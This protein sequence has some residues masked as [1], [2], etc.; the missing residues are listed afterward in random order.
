MFNCHS[1]HCPFDLWAPDQRSKIENVAFSAY[2]KSTQDIEDFIDDLAAATNPNDMA[3]QSRLAAAHDINLDSLTRQ[4]R[5]YIE[6]EVA[7]RYVWR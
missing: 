1:S 4:E 2:A 7:K 6:S 3:T 5:E